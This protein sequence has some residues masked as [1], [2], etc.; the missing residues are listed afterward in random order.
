M[1]ATSYR[2]ATRKLRARYEET[3]PVEFSLYG[4][5]VV[6]VYFETVTFSPSNEGEGGNQPFAAPSSVAPLAW[7]G[8]EVWSTVLLLLAASQSAAA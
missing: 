7:F 8:F 6:D 5:S 3:A 4:G 1:L 2:L